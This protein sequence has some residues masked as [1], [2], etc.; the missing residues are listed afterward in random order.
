VAKTRYL[1]QLLVDD[2]YFSG[3]DEVMGELSDAFN[4]YNEDQQIELISVEVDPNQE[5]V[6]ADKG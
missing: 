5:G 2:E 3:A 6:N 4:Y 1:V